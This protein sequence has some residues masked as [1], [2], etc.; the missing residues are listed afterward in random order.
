[1]AHRSWL[2]A[3]GPIATLHEILDQIEVHLH[4]LGERRPVFEAAKAV[5]DQAMADGWGELDIASVHD[6]ISTEDALT[7][8]VSK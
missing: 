2:P 8:G 7:Q 1:M 5:F 6:Q 4:D 3:P